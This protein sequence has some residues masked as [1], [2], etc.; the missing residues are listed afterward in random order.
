M[1]DKELTLVDHMTELR[2]R[3]IICIISV[4]VGAS[5]SYFE[6]KTILALLI[7]PVGKLVFITPQEAFV[8]YIKLAI[9]SGIFLAM[10]VILYQIWRFVAVGL[11][12]SEKKYLLLYGP[13]SF[14]LFLIGAAFA[15]FVILPLGIKFL[16]GFATDTLKPMISLKAYVSFA[17][18]LLLVFGVVF[19][20]P[21]VIIFLTKIRLVTTSLLREKRKVVI[22]LIFILA[23]ILT[24]PDIITQILMAGPLILLYEI[25]ILLSTL[26]K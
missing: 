24:P 12:R 19:E 6:I 22:V 2:R 9:F 14:I 16:L 10:P 5:L 4:I 17:G 13:F 3:L 21:L 8:T 23:A 7:K 26:V 25:S 1:A 15:Y 11:K 18:M 20:L